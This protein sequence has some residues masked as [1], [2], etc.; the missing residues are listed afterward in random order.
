MNI[1]NERMRGWEGRVEEEGN[2]KNGRWEEI[3][4]REE[5]SICII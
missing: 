1:G 5:Y 3:R 4:R 2:G